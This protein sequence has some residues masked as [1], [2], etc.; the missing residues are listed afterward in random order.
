MHTGSREACGHTL[1][2]L[3]ND[4]IIIQSVDFTQ[5]S[6]KLNAQVSVNVLI[7]E[8]GVSDTMCSIIPKVYEVTKEIVTSINHRDYS[9]SPF[10]FLVYIIMYEMYE[11]TTKCIYQS[12]L[13]DDD[14]YIMTTIMCDY[15]EYNY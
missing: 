14:G 15:S 7:E 10:L 11:R 6:I 12:Q 4:W 2:E 3:N 13:K 9:L 5:L 1:S 8:N